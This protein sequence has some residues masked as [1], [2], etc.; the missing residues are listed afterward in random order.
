MQCTA[1]ETYYKADPDK[2]DGKK[3]LTRDPRRA[4]SHLSMITVACGKCMDCRLLHTFTWSVRC[5]HELR[6]SSGGSFVTLT[7]DKEH[8][9]EDWSLRYRDFQLFMHKVRNS[10]RSGPEKV[11][12]FMCGEYGDDFGRP[13]Y[14]AILFNKVFP[15]R[16]YHKREGDIVLYKSD[17]LTAL[18]GN[19]FA[20]LG[21]VTRHSAGYVARYSLKKIG[22]PLAGA[23]YQFVTPDGVVVDR[24]PP[25]A[26]ASSRP[27]IGASW[28]ERF[29]S[30]V[31]PHDNMIVDGK[32]VPVPR[33]Y[34]KLLDRWDPAMSEE[35]KQA[36]RAAAATGY[37]EAEQSGPRLYVKQE[38]RLLNSRN[39]QRNKGL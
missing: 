3:G 38:V 17:E 27:G 28:L 10:M 37:D 14:H 6:M 7:Y 19:G 15:D 25:F 35:L 8:L 29:R 24:R 36:R 11:R 2:N 26:R 30:D 18:W 34:R 12:F 31:F 9:P 13:H 23:A 5:M 32:M 22:G 21:D 16:K 20:S 39:V 4:L 33:Y 1:P